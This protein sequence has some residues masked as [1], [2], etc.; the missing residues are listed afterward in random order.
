MGWHYILWR[1]IFPIKRIKNK[2]LHLAANTAT[3]NISAWRALWHYLQFAKNA[4]ALA[5]KI[6]GRLLFSWKLPPA[7]LVLVLPIGPKELA[8]S[9]IIL[10]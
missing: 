5:G 3:G 2:K 4:E 1:V 8:F 9:M 7:Q 10:Q 6:R